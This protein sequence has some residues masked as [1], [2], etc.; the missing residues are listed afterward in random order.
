MR[1]QVRFIFIIVT[2]LVVALVAAAP[3]QARPVT[4]DRQYY[5]SLGDSLAFGYQP[6]LVAEHD[7]NPADYRSYAEHFAALAH[8]LRLVNYGCPGETTTTLV[9]GGCPWPYPLHDSYGS[10]TSQLGAARS[11]LTAHPGRVS[12]V[13]IDI[14]SNDLLGLVGGCEASQPTTLPACLAAG[15]PRTLSTIASNYATVLATLQPLARHARFVLFTLYNPLALTL[16][17]SDALI[18]VVNQAL[19]GLASAAHARLADAF[20]AINGTA[21]SA[22]E[23]A[24]ICALTWECTSYANVHPT[25]LGYWSL[26]FALGRSLR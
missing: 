26:T 22:Q 8:R 23:K 21:G 17:G 13:T 3:A 14:G 1:R 12:L 15:L 16:P 6:D 19:A 9:Q 18:A 4:P 24:R 20:R 25:T 2:A 5:L 7:V 10:A 11:F